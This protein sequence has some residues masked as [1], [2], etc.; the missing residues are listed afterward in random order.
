MPTH[1][2]KQRFAAWM[3][4]NPTA[5]EK[6]VGKLIGGKDNPWGFMP[7]QIEHGYILD[8]YSPK[9]RVAIEADGPDHFRKSQLVQDHLRD[10]A[11]LSYGIR[12]IRFTPLHLKKYPQNFLFSYIENFIQSVIEADGII[13]GADPEEAKAFGPEKPAAL[14]D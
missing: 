6:A 8:F 7:Q 1:E 10:A 13:D 9:Y 4:C 3:N 2:S 11:L 14:Q 12:T 5:F